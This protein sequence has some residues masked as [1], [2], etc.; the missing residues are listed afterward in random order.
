VCIRELWAIIAGLQG[1]QS[2]HK[3]SPPEILVCSFI[4]S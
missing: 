3:H 1:G 4:T 2:W